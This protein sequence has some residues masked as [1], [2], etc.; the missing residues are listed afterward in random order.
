MAPVTSNQLSVGPGSDPLKY[1]IR[2]LLPS[3]VVARTP[4]NTHNQNLDISDC[5]KSIYDRGLRVYV[6][7]GSALY[8]NVIKSI[9]R[10]IILVTVYWY[11]IALRLLVYQS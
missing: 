9:Y 4:V 1:S 3:L 8:G 10:R 5:T 7:Q 11:L 2:V 6:I